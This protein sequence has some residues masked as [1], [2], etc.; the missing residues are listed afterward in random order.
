MTHTR[1]NKGVCSRYT[2]VT[3]QGGIIQQVAVED[4]CDGNLQGLCAM[5]QGQKATDAIERLQNITCDSKKTSCPA[6]IA[7]CLAEALATETN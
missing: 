4:G 7:A 6:Q 3:L 5:L 2:T 1:K